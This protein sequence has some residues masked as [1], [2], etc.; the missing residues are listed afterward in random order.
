MKRVVI[1]VSEELH[2]DLKVYCF[3]NG[4]TV[5]EYLTKLVEKDLETKKEQTR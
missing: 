3:S 5:K 2:R 1:E 4:T